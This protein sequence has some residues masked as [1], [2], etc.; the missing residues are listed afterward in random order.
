MAEQRQFRFRLPWL[1]APTTPPRP[2][3]ETEPTRLN[4]TTEIRAPPQPTTTTISSQRPPFRPPGIAPPP[5]PP[6]PA[7]AASRP[8]TESQPA[9]PIRTRRASSIPPSPSQSVIRSLLSE[10]APAA[11]SASPPQKRQQKSPTED[12]A[13]VAK[14][15]QGET[16]RNEDTKR[17][18][19]TEAISTSGDSLRNSVS[20]FLSSA[21]QA[22]QP[23]FLRKQD[24]DNREDIHDRKKTSDEIIKAVNST[25]HTRTR[26]AANGGGGEQVPFHREI[27]EEVSKLV[28][29]LGQGNTKQPIGD[30]PVSM[31]TLAGENRGA[32]MHFE[33][34]PERKDGSLHIHRGYKT[35]PDDSIESTTDG[36]GIRKGKRLKHEITKDEQQQPTMAYVNSNSQSI[37]NSILLDS[38]VNERNPGVHLS[39]S[40]NNQLDSNESAA[41]NEEHKT[42]RSEV[43]VTP[44]EKLTYEPRLRRRCLRGLFLET[45]DSDPDN[46][47]KPRRHGCRYYACGKT[48]KDNDI[49]GPLE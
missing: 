14:E 47:D 25:S 28:H 10:G 24:Q 37:N 4:L 18:G 49:G 32:T 12:I 42:H 16:K 9:S 45:S 19:K 38:K 40:H 26:K 29:K 15:P 8:T 30:H 1:S 36:E 43:S 6:P 31:V 13:K 17:E 41:S 22:R 35:N 5:P 3:P 48:N 7:A 23:V 34:E 21:S 33:G 39:L 20:E 27:K 46:P 11:R 44:A 2:T